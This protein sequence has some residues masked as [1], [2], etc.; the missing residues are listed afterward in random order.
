MAKN[1]KKIK[2][3]QNSLEAQQKAGNIDK[4]GY[5]TL[6]QV[7]Q[8]RGQLFNPVKLQKGI[9]ENQQEILQTPAAKRRNRDA[10]DPF[11]NGFFKKTEDQSMSKRFNPAAAKNAVDVAKEEQTNAQKLFAPA[12]PDIQTDKAGNK[13]ASKNGKPV[14]FSGTPKGVKAPDLGDRGN[15]NILGMT[16]AERAQN[17]QSIQNVAAN[18]EPYQLP[19]PTQAAPALAKTSVPMGAVEQM[20]FLPGGNPAGASQ[21]VL[22]QIPSPAPQT[23][24]QASN[25][26]TGMAN[27]I[28]VKGVLP[29]V[30]ANFFDGLYGISDAFNNNVLSPINKAVS[31]QQPPVY[32]E[33]GRYQQFLRDQ[34]LP[35]AQ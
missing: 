21:S 33:R 18:F 16:D 32:N 19:Q 4:D 7:P 31:G 8:E 14:G 24:A 1:R 6:P 25:L 10:E 27:T 28:P 20:M 12:V 30:G 13:L 9:A 22:P 5:Y 11:K 2:Q 15:P 34:A 3:G 17:Q 35:M 29:W 23:T 26:N